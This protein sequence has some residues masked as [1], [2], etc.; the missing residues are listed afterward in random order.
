MMRI[1][2]CLILLCACSSL[3][4]A[5]VQAIPDDV[6]NQ[7]QLD[8]H[9]QKFMDAGGLPVVGSARVSDAAIR[10]AAWVVQH[11]LVAR[12][13]LLRA[14]GEN[15]T[16][17]A[18]MAYNE[19]TTDIPEHRSL[20]PRVYWDRRARGL[21]A[22]PEAPAVSCAEE[23]LLCFPGDPYATENI[24]VHEFAHAIHEMGMSK[25]DPTF[26]TR[27]EQAYERAM[28]GKLW[29]QTYAAVNR[30]EYWAEGT[31]SWFDNNRANDALHND[32]DTREELKQYDRSEER[33]GGKECRSRWSTNH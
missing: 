25:L 15:N 8:R 32:V 33:R 5:D 18:V 26:D 3:V 24:C 27:L 22:T 4:Q 9:Y 17:L 30:H 7:F 19:Y 13:E 16:R 31:Q 14:M 2:T 21:G 29:Q 23:I 28:N 10:E 6:R 1:S 20:T 12:S 11:M